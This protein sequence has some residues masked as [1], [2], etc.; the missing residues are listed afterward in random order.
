MTTAFNMG[1]GTT[2]ATLHT[3][4]L[5]Q[6]FLGQLSTVVAQTKHRECGV[7]VF[8]H[9]CIL[10]RVERFLAAAE[11]HDSLDLPG[12]RFSPR[13]VDSRLVG[14]G[15][16]GA[17]ATSRTPSQAGV[18]D[19]IL[20]SASGDE[21]HN[22]SSTSTT[23]AP[24]ESSS[25]PSLPTFSPDTVNAVRRLA[26]LLRSGCLHGRYPLHDLAAQRTASCTCRPK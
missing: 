16:G 23:I 20:H 18:S 24:R 6:V 3:H 1:A 8:E 25:Y 21:D 13:C 19:G 5:R 12:S 15:C 11:A 17:A 7:S 26:T 14:Q 4:L 10:G 2:P 22:F 9:Y